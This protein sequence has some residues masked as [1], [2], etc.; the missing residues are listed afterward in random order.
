MMQRWIIL[1]IV[2]SCQCF[3]VYS[4]KK[5]QALIDQFNSFKVNHPKEYAYLQTDKK[6]YFNGESIHVEMMFF[7]QFMR[8]SQL[9]KVAYIE[10]IHEDDLFHK[11][12]VFKVADGLGKGYISIPYDM[13]TGN[14]QLVAYTYFMNNFSLEQQVH[15]RTIY[16]QQIGETPKK[17]AKDIITTQGDDSDIPLPKVNIRSNETNTRLFFEITSDTRISTD[18][19]VIIEGFNGIQLVAKT[20]LNRTT[21]NITIPKAQ[22]KGSFFR[23]VVVDE[24]SQLLGVQPFYLKA[25]NRLA[26]Q[27]NADSVQVEVNNNSISRLTLSAD[28]LHQDSIDLF[29]RTYQVFYQVPNVAILQKG[30]LSE[31]VAEEQLAAYAK[32]SYHYWE[33]LLKTQSSDLVLES[34]PERN[35]HLRG[36]LRG[37]LSQLKGAVLA[38]HFFYNGLDLLQ[39]LD[40]SGSFNMEI[41]WPLSSDRFFSTIV[42]ESKDDISD[43]YDISFQTELGFQYEHNVDY[44]EVAFTDSIIANRSQF[45]YILST[46][47]D[48]PEVTNYFWEDKVIDKVIYTDD[49]RDMADFEEFV[50]E[51]IA[52]LTVVNKGNERMLRIYNSNKGGFSEPQL[53]IVDNQMLNSSTPLFDIPIEKIASVR[54][55]YSK[56]KLEEFGGIFSRGIVILTLKEGIAISNEYIEAYGGVIDGFNHNEVNEMHQLFNLT[57]LHQCFSNSVLEEYIGNKKQKGAFQLTIE[58]ITQDG[59]YMNHV[60]RDIHP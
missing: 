49:Y 56:E 18:S 1:G 19:Y 26:I 14:Y 50:K 7:D 53:I 4:Q 16:I 47:G 24:N 37:D 43:N 57:K 12:Y 6:I 45:S 5:E 40:E 58:S 25:D 13:P 54:M 30:S 2:L 28:V 36:S 21:N 59:T 44:H 15:R 60:H 9:S 22:L 33:G 39:P 42:S 10:M 29:R 11:K 46:Y 41:F 31:L 35:I 52:D 23:M 38:V 17:V 55:T 32:Y 3:G 8:P 20:K 27:S 34:L 48:E 51:A